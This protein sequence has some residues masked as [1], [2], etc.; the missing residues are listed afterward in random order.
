MRRYVAVAQC[1]RRSLHS[2]L[3]RHKLWRRLPQPRVPATQPNLRVTLWLQYNRCLQLRRLF[4]QLW[5]LGLH[6]VRLSSNPR[7][8]PWMCQLTSWRISISS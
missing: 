1:P 3:C 6:R 5:S 2:R 7:K 4:L 8:Q